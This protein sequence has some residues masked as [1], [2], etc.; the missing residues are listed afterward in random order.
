MLLIRKIL[1]HLLLACSF[2]MANA[3]NTQW[4]SQNM[5]LVND[6]ANVIVSPNGKFVA[7]SLTKFENTTLGLKP[8]I[9]I[10]VVNLASHQIVFIKKGLTEITNLQWTPNGKGLYFLAKVANIRNID[11]ILLS[12]DK[13]IQLTHSKTD[14]KYFKIAPNGK[15]IAYIRANTPATTLLLAPTIVDTKIDC[16]NIWLISSTVSGNKSKKSQVLTKFLKENACI[17][18]TSLDWAPNG[19]SLA[20]SHAPANQHAIWNYGKISIINIATKTIHKLSHFDMIQHQPLYS[21][22]GK[23]LAYTSRARVYI[24]SIKTKGTHALAKTPNE[25]PTLIGWSADSKKVYVL[26]DYHTYT[27]ILSLSINSNDINL[28][29]PPNKLIQNVTINQENKLFAFTMQD[30]NHPITAYVSYLSHFHPQKISQH[31]QNKMLYL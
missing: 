29:S 13:I 18:I 19:K 17:N 2:S 8:N 10:I 23:W 3:A 4:T 15:V 6:V 12:Q 30:N 1:L 21:P 11:Y 25:Q 9:A 24:V 5:F 22:D 28:L 16:D 7:F 14:I 20:Y 26:E 27:T 31:N